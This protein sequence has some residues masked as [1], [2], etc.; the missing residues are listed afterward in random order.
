MRHD[1]RN[2]DHNGSERGDICECEDIQCQCHGLCDLPAV[3]TMYETDE[4]GNTSAV[5]AEMC[6]DCAFNAYELGSHMSDND[7]DN[8]A[9]FDRLEH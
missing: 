2:L 3:Y 4:A 5:S 8:D 6:S 9:L 7:K 1:Y